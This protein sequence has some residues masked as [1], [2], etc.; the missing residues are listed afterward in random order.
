M[1]T[2]REILLVVDFRNHTS[3]NCTATFTNCELKTFFNSN[4]SNQFYC[5]CYVITRH[6][7]FYTF[8]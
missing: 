1:S 6:N 7:H 2:L 3:T 4:W 5:K 8:W